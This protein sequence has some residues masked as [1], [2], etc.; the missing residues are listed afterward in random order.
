MEVVLD[1]KLYG[2]QV[3]GAN[4]Q[5]ILNDMASNAFDGDRIL[6][7]VT[8]NGQPYEEKVF[9]PATNLQRES[10]QR[11]EV[12]TI[13]SREVAMHFMS[14]S[15]AYLDTIIGSVERVSELFRVSD[16]QEA[17]ENYLQTLESL[18][19]FLQVLQNVRES[20]A[21]DFNQAKVGAHTASQRLDRLSDLVKEMLT[22]QEQEDWVLLAD[23]L[24]YD[25]AGELRAW[26]N[27]IP[28]LKEQTLS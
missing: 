9:G 26:R 22:A 6:Q 16:E 5:D 12:Q 25:L 23:I 8:I 3:A 19:L 20:L 24:Q 10:I 21:L 1:G 4:L 11:L 13:A 17:N 18:Q 15:T 28:L 7:E 27:L 14:N 2:S